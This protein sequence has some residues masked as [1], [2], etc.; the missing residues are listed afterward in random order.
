VVRQNSKFRPKNVDQSHL[1]SDECDHAGVLA[2]LDDDIHSKPLSCTATTPS[3]TSTDTESI[4]LS[5]SAVPIQ[6]AIRFPGSWISGSEVC[7]ETPPHGSVADT[8]NKAYPVQVLEW[9]WQ[10]VAAR[11]TREANRIATS[12]LRFQPPFLPLECIKVDTVLAR[13]GLSS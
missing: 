9:Y 4:R 1:R 5:S 11:P 7:E 13:I 6:Q 8:M 3:I 12:G 2:R 10:T